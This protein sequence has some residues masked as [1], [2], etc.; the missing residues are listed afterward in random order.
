MK[1]LSNEWRISNF[2][3]TA[4]FTFLY[5]IVY[6]FL[7]TF[8]GKLMYHI[9]CVKYF[10]GVT[11][12]FELICIISLYNYVMENFSLLFFQSH[13]KSCSSEWNYCRK[14]KLRAI[15]DV[16]FRDVFYFRLFLTF[17]IYFSHITFGSFNLFLFLVYSTSCWR[18]YV[19]LTL[20]IR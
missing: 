5:K 13:P 14:R 19:S 3:C 7:E 2:Y 15:S 4:V 16:C 6:L 8:A 10:K 9:M 18:L 1:F 11:K 17:K 12:C 20:S